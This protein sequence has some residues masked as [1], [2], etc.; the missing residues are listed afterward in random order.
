MHGFWPDVLTKSKRK[1]VFNEALAISIPNDGTS[2]LPHAT[3]FS[4]SC[5]RIWLRCIRLNQYLRTVL[6]C[7]STDN[8]NSGNLAFLM[9]PPHQLVLIKA[10]STLKHVLILLDLQTFQVMLVP[11][12][13]K[14]DTSY[15]PTS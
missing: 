15:N 6:E 5:I 7:V 3:S 8:F 4:S 9:V 12:E 1:T 11:V 2:G 10:R 14:V 13:S